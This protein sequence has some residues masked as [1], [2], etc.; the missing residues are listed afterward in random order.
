MTG[1]MRTILLYLGLATVVLGQTGMLEG[2]RVAISPQPNSNF[3]SDAY[4]IGFPA[5]SCQDVPAQLLGNVRSFQPHG[6]TYCEL[7]E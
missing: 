2:P 1:T 3:T 7:Y 5:G 6:G 4:S